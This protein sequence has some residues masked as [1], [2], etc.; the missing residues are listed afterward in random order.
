MKSIIIILIVIVSIYLQIVDSHIAAVTHRRIKRS[1][2]K[3]N[4]T[5]TTKTPTI[6][7]EL[8]GV[9]IFGIVGVFV[10]FFYMYITFKKTELK[11]KN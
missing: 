9:D 11:T 10:V 1:H 8:N 3:Y 2:H 7:R 5:N 6:P 4:S